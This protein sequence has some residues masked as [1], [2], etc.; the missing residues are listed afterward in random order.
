MSICCVR[1][2]QSDHIQ[3]HRIK[4]GQGPFR[5]PL[6]YIVRICELCRDALIDKPVGMKYFQC[7]GLAFVHELWEETDDNATV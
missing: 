2:C 4:G 3:E 6:T 7:G 5:K 1:A